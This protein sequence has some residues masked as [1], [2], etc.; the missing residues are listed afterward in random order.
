MK[1][2]LAGSRAES[3]TS[4]F[5]WLWGP[6]SGEASEEDG[7]GQSIEWIDAETALR[8]A[9]LLGLRLSE[10]VDLVRTSR[11]LG[12]EPSRR[13]AEAIESLARRGL[14]TVDQ[15]RLRIPEKS[16]LFA[17]SIITRLL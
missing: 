16:W 3:K 15:G 5:G 7:T 14:L 12:L 8:E 17:N 13:R 2:M 11:E 6:S 10:G 4:T 1:A 9:L